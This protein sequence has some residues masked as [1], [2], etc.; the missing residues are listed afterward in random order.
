MQ[1]KT[2]KL[3]GVLLALTIGIAVMSAKIGLTTK[4]KNADN[5]NKH[6]RVNSFNNKARLAKTGDEQA[7]NDF[8]DEVFSQFAPP[9]AADAFPLFKDR[10]V[11]AEA[12]YRRTGK[13]GIQEKNVVGAFNELAKQIGA[14]D[15]AKVSVRQLRFLRL[16]AMGAFPGLIGQPKWTQSNNSV[17]DS[18]M[19]PLEAVGMSLWLG[20]QKLANEDFQVT[21]NEWAT[22]RHQKEVAKWEA[23]RKGRSDLD[24]KGNQKGDQSVSADGNSR[25]Q[26]LK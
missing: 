6:E 5:P 17:I 14:P 4:S 26:E 8:A 21:P 16:N 24:N 1:K 22:K 2:L 7:V 25:T 3:F 10:I 13:G 9:E 15:Y 19:S 23:N 11:R 18:E 12:N 20:N